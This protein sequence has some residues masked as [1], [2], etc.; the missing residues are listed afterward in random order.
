MSGV[1]AMWARVVVTRSLARFVLACLGGRGA[2]RRSSTPRPQQRTITCGWAR[3]ARG[4]HGV[5]RVYACIRD[6]SVRVC[7]VV[8]LSAQGIFAYYCHFGRTS[9]SGVTGNSVDGAQFAKFC[10]E[11]PGLMGERARFVSLRACLRM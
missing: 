6:S 1:R 5:L 2:G 10:R 7:V 11:S 9:T 4:R 3:S 8:C